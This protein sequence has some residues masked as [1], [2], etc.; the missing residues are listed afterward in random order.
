MHTVRKKVTCAKNL[1][2]HKFKIKMFQ[3]CNVLQ[4]HYKKNNDMMT[5]LVIMP[6]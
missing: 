5:K 4:Q 2:D 1:C 3:Y 6:K